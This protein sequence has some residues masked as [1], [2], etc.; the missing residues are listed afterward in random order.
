MESINGWLL[1]YLIG[2]V[3]LLVFYAMRP[4]TRN[5]P[6]WWTSTRTA[7][8]TSS[9]ITRSLYEMLAGRYGRREPIR[10]G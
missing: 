5:T 10:I 3:P 6:G 8:R 2:L 7:S 4:T 1:V 9:C